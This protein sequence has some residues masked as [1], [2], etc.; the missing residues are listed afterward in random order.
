MARLLAV[1]IGLLAH[2]AVSTSSSRSGIVDLG[3]SQ[4][5]G[6]SLSNGVDEFL[7]MR[8]AKPALDNLRF[9]APQDPE[10]TDGVIDATEV[11]SLFQFE[12][13]AQL[14]QVTY[15]CSLGLFALELV[16]AMMA[17]PKTVCTSMFGG[18][19]TRQLMLVSLFG[20]SSLGVDTPI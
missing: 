10:Q 4:Y 12:V 7:S 5:Q 9:R 3:Y 8:Y 6:N 14:T 13:K 2:L 16:K 19:I 17:T 18:Q 11:R 1:V 20:C 15:T